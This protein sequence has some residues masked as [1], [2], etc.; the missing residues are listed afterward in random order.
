MTGR[1]TGMVTFLFT[2]IEGSTRRW[3]AH[4][5][6][7]P[8]AFARQE[9]I[10]RE[11]VATYGGWAYKQVGDAFQ[12]AFQ[13]A[14]A[15]LAAAL[16]AQQALAAE[17]WPAAIGPV[18]VRMALHTGSAEERGDDYVGPAL[19]HV[20]RLLSAGHGGQILLTAATQNLVRD[21]SPASVA[22][23]DL[24]ERHLKDL[25]HPE[26]I[27][28]ATGPALPADFPPLKTLDTR[29]NNL[30]ST[31]TALI[32]RAT[33]RAQGE[34]LL[35]RP[36]VRLLT[37]TGP[38]GVGKTR[39]ALQLAADL[40]PDF[41][42][43]VWFI[44]LAAVEDADLL[45]ATIAGALGLRQEPGRSLLS[46]LHDHLRRQQVL[47]ILDNFEQVTEGA[48]LVSDLLGGAPGLK[49]L[50]TSRVR[51]Y[52][53]GEK[54]LAL[55]PLA[56]PAPDPLAD[57]DA[58]AR[59]PAVALF[60]ERAADAQ[61]GFMLTPENAGAVAAICRRLDGLPLAI[62]LAA[63]RSKILAPPALLAR[64]ESRL[65]LLTRGAGDLPAHQQT[66]RDT[67]TWSYNLLGAGEQQIF[68]QLAV[69]AG[70]FTLAA[71]E[72]VCSAPN[73]S[74][75]TA[76]TPGTY[77]ANDLPAADVLDRL[78]ALLDQSL[79]QSDPGEETRFR[80]L[81]TIREYAWDRLVASGEAA[82]IRQRHAAYFQALAEAADAG[83]QG[84]RQ[85]VWRQRLAVEH[86]NLRAALGW[87]EETA[88]GE[89]GARLAGALARFWATHGYLAEGRRW[90]EWALQ[91]A[92]TVPITQRAR[93]LDGASEI[94]YWQAD[95]AAARAWAE[96]ALALRRT[97][98]YQAPIAEA[99]TNLGRILWRLGDRAGAQA[100]LAESQAL[101]RA[102]GAAPPSAETQR[103]PSGDPAVGA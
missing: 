43:G 66:L 59:I 34:A 18:R 95:Y 13:T 27:W 73:A 65:P 90:L 55:V 61:I 33:E 87:A 70:G 6:L 30:P 58:L 36:D 102:S 2:D 64:L 19:Y 38:P 92:Q 3:E 12:V 31:L 41:A 46:S 81:E 57:L 17:P 99:L 89:A 20:H 16:A 80:M 60:V 44:A 101:R 50:V 25:A 82:A 62:E 83:W 7:M 22:L 93:L 28:Q 79:L 32:G 98:G 26:H 9:A 48:R 103:H 37:V 72:V 45:T 8:A 5:D 94:A 21:S 97:L 96:E 86:D 29:P 15:A 53:R 76:G 85:A 49:V 11:A 63:V 56:L 40:L 47:L 67:I 100:L 91:S 88:Q 4:P 78:T 35:G 75:R 23:R 39:F 74:Q 77:T 69:F 68:R 14:P 54:E 1:P 24:G 71:A 10:L 51:L 42:D 84:T 52:L